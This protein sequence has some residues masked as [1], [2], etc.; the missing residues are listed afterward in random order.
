MLI[1]E[2]TRLLQQECARAFLCDEKNVHVTWGLD[3]HGDPR[4][5]I[6]LPPSRTVVVLSE[7]EVS[8]RVHEIVQG[9][10][11]HWIQITV[12]ELSAPDFAARMAAKRT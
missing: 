8:R 1:Q 10:R 3:K 5:E 4:P 12:R 9:L 7:A 11:T 6:T 2:C